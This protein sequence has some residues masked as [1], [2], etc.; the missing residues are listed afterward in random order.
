MTYPIQLSETVRI[1]K[2]PP[3]RIATVTEALLA[4]SRLASH[5]WLGAPDAMGKPIVL[6]GVMLYV[7]WKAPECDHVFTVYE[8]ENGRYQIRERYV[9]EAEALEAARALI[10]A[11]D[12]LSPR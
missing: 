10:G 6:G 9:T 7:D 11:S 4:G 2:G 8:L 5:Y 3:M 12:G 1:D